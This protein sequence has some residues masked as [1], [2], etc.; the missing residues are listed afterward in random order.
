MTLEIEILC[1][2]GCCGASK[3]VK[4]DVKPLVDLIVQLEVL[5]TNLLWSETFFQSLRFGCR[6]VFIGSTNIKC[7]VIPF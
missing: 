7:V 3:V 4:V 1:L 5:V 2:L 6:T